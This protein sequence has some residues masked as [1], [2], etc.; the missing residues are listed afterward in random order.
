MS[1]RNCPPGAQARLY[2]GGSPLECPNLSP[3][4]DCTQELRRVRER[5]Y[6][7]M[8]SNILSVVS[9]AALAVGCARFS[10]T[11]TERNTP[12]GSPPSA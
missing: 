12:D 9:L 5:N 8:K 3:L 6:S 2:P 4:Q 11:V 10:S 7:K 1:L